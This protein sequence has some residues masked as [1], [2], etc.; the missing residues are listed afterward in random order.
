MQ[1]EI[2]FIFIAF[3]II[4]C[5][6]KDNKKEHLNEGTFYNLDPNVINNLDAGLYPMCE[7][8]IRS[9]ATTLRYCND[10]PSF[11][12]YT[13]NLYNSPFWIQTKYPSYFYPPYSSSDTPHYMY[14]PDWWHRYK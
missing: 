6:Y 12:K 10:L 5:L 3:A 9:N 7:K 13:S 14:S 2:L 8:N 11:K 4:L 1:K